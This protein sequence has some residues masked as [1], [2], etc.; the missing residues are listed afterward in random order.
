LNIRG[1][2]GEHVRGVD[3]LDW[4]RD[5]ASNGTTERCLDGMAPGWLAL[6]IAAS[7][8]LGPA[9]RKRPG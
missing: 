2:V 7:E 5:L 8:D 1:V 6:S 9:G 3:Q 4:S